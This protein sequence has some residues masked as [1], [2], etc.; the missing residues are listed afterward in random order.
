LSY[1]YVGV[2]ENC[3]FNPSNIGANATAFVVLTPGDENVLK[4]AVANVG[5]ISVAIEANGNFDSYAGG[6]YDDPE[7]H[8][9]I[10]HMTHAVLIVGYGTDSDTGKDYW[11]VKNSWNTSWGEEGYIKMVRN[12]KNQCAIATLASY[13]TVKPMLK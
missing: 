6:V 8:S 7:C 5:P 10:D 2:D 9:D 11:L 1:P 13:I 4:E 12:K 3:A